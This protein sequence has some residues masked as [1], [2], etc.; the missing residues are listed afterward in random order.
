M[1]DTLMGM[2]DSDINQRTIL[3]ALLDAHARMLGLDDLGVA[4]PDP[5]AVE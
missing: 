3:R 5:A 4:I 2:T 1:F